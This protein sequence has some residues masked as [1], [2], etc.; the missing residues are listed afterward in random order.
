ME[1]P[2]RYRPNKVQGARRFD[3]AKSRNDLYKTKEWNIFRFR[4][5]HH[6]PKCY[7]CPMDSEHVDHMVP[8]RSD[9]DGFFKKGNHVPLCH[10]CHSTVTQ[11]F[12]LF[13]PPR[14]NDKILWMQGQRKIHGIVRAIRVIEV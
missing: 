7:V 13:D 6:N 12:D 1:R 10:S 5:L 3:M 14:T 8:T 11:L 9:R 4:F 2:K